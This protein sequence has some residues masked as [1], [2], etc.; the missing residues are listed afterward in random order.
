MDWVKR[1]DEW[2]RWKKVVVIAGCR[3]RRQGYE[4]EK[5]MVLLGAG[6]DD[7][8][9]TGEVESHELRKAVAAL[10]KDVTVSC[11]RPLF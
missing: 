3:L 2:D 7:K 6:E 10:M 4:R 1:G 9:R 5:D 11:D 8:V